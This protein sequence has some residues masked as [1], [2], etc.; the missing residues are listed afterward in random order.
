MVA[1]LIAHFEAG[2]TGLTNMRAFLIVILH[3]GVE[4]PPCSVRLVTFGAFEVCLTCS[5]Q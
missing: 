5:A 2:I 1:E 3:V 4:T